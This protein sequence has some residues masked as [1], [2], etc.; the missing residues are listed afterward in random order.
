MYLHDHLA[1]TIAAQH[2][3]DQIRESRAKRLVAAALT[4]APT[5]PTSVRAHRLLARVAL[6]TR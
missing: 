1:L 5:T 3:A 2:Q 6:A 4:A